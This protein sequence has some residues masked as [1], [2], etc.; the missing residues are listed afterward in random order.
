VTE[1]KFLGETIFRV[2]GRAFAFVGRPD[3]AAVTLKPPPE[4]IERLLREPRV[5]RARY[6][7]RFGWLTVMMRDEG[8]VRLAL[9]LVDESY[10]HAAAG[11]RRRWN[12][13]RY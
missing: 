5:R 3:R 7:G 13:K 1:A 4:D 12:G 2:R 9:A 10:R 6:I 11:P 8:S